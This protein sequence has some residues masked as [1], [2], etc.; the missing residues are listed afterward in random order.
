MAH[1]VSMLFVMLAGFLLAAM[2]ARAVTLEKMGV[3]DM[4][5][6]ADTVF[7]G[8]V[9][10]VEEQAISLG[11]GEIPTVVYR[12]RVE[13][14]LKGQATYTKGDHSVVEFRMVGSIKAPT[15]NGDLRNLAVFRDVPN[16]K[17]G[18]DYVLFMTPQSA[19]G[20]S[21]TVGL[22]QGAFNVFRQEKEDYAM[23]LYNNSNLDNGGA[24]VSYA[25]LKSA[26]LAAGQ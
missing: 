4:A 7:R 23:N 25:D 6:R 16:L 18:S 15:S 10:D 14:M 1:R 2:P 11:G 20:L 8:T 9:I 3:A 12:V 5:G 21:V 19:A 24:A 17:I 26:I 13:E 22:G